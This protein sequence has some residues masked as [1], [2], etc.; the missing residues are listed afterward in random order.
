[1]FLS[2]L[3]EI[4]DTMQ[5]H[6]QKNLCYHPAPLTM[7]ILQY[8]VTSIDDRAFDGVSHIYYNGTATG[9]PWGAKII[10]EHELTIVV[11][12]SYYYQPTSFVL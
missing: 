1:M 8:S 12:N 2:K 4:A 5:L 3:G 9:A 11:Y 7:V 10:Y 6:L